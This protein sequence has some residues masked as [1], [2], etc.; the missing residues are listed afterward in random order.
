MYAPNNDGLVTCVVV[1]KAGTYRAATEGDGIESVFENAIRS[2][3]LGAAIDRTNRAIGIPWY[4]IV[5][6]I[7]GVEP[8]PV[9]Q[10][11]FFGD[12]PQL[13]AIAR[14]YAP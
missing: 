9:G 13:L 8:T 2:H 11:K 10:R 1:E 3:R 7:E 5:S 12:N 4:R 6:S 14:M